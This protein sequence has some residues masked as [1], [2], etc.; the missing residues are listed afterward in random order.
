MDLYQT[1][2][3]AYDLPQELIAKYPSEPR[4]AARLLH[5]N[6]LTGE[7]GDYVF[8][9]IK[10]FFQPGDAL[11]LNETKVIPARLWAQ[12]A[13]GAKVEIMLIKPR[14]DGSWEALVRPAKRL[15]PGTP[16]RIMANHDLE[17]IIEDE[18]PMPGGRSIR[19]P[20]QYQAL[21]LIE[22]Y[23]SMP[24]PP[25]L[26]RDAQGADKQD[27]QTVYAKVDG[28]VAAPTAGLHF[29]NTLLEE[30]KAKGVLIIPL[31][32][33]V[34]IGTFRPVATEDIRSHHMHQEWYQLGQNEANQL[35]AVKKA[36]HKII[37]VGT[38]A[39]RTLETV[40]RNKQGFVAGEGETDIFIYPGYKF[41]AIDGLIT[42]FH[43]PESTLL[44]LVSALAGWE[45]TFTAYRH[46]VKEHYR[47]FS[48]G[49]AM[50]IGSTK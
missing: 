3:Y 41:Q 48:Y 12:K 46:A 36:G 26:G 34:G 8:H 5:L 35:N 31:L 37:A 4:D 19:F 20:A 9:Q 38:T 17:I 7:I 47:F 29:T 45:N 2:A 24:L 33:H 13:T 23:G 32:L 21:Q 42:N 14:T 1:K 16:V 25:Y 27:Y 28:S 30:L 11:V 18:L 10:D 39:V 44:M 40:Y 50:Y 22:T 49:D 43:L 15:P 6:P